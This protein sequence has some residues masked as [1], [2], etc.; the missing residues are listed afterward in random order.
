MIGRQIIKPLVKKQIFNDYSNVKMNRPSLSLYCKVYSG[1][2]RDFHFSKYSPTADKFENYK[3]NLGSSVTETSELI[4][5]R[6]QRPISPHLTIYEPEISW[7]LSSLHRIT[8]LILGAGFFFTTIV[9]GSALLFRV[10]ESSEDIIRWYHKKISRPI[11]LAGKFAVSYFFAFHTL[12]G[13][14]H[15]VWDTG[16]QLSNQAV[17]KSGYTVLILTALLGTYIFYK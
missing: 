6:K 12:N 11:D 7:Y 14:R 5:K 16:L 9:L 10:N 2:A 1:F 8:G 13:V 4:K 17:T 3:L 15:L